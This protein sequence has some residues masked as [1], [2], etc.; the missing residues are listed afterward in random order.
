M[1]DS[2]A[3]EDLIHRVNQRKKDDEARKRAKENDQS[4]LAKIAKSK[5]LRLALA[6][7]GAVG[8]LKTIANHSQ[9]AEA[10]GDDITTTLVQKENVQK[11]DE[12]VVEKHEESKDLFDVVY[13]DLSPQEREAARAE[14]DMFKARIQEKVGWEKEHID[15]PT[16]YKAQIIQSARAYGLKEDMLMGI[17]SIENGGGTDIENSGSGA[18]GVAQFLP[19]TARQ[20]G[21]KVNEVFDERTNPGKSIAAAGSYLEDHKALFDG[22]EGITIWSYH[23]GEGNVYN[24][25]RVYFLDKYHKDIGDYVN[26]RNLEETN[27]IKAKAF[28]YMEMDHLDIYKLLN[29]EAVKKKVLSKLDDYTETYVPQVVALIELM[30]DQDQQAPQP[31]DLVLQ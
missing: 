4:K 12:E 23:A 19:E 28:E 8:A 24:A 7:V 22:D 18:V 10:A 30:K 14:V 20:Y 1:N 21:L 11:V 9:G 26:S 25:M 15:I 3:E 16:K 13:H 29:N 17:I 31:A 2:P 27:A 5:S 6:T